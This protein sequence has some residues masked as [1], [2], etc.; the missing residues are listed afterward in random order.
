MIKRRTF[1]KHDFYDVH[2]TD[3]YEKRVKETYIYLSEAKNEFGYK[4]Y[5]DDFAD[6]WINRVKKFATDLEVPRNLGVVEPEHFSDTYSHV[7]VP[8][9]ETTIFLL[10]ED[11]QIY[12]ATSGWSRAPWRTILEERQSKIEQ[13]ISE[14]KTEKG[15]PKDNKIIKPMSERSA[16]ERAKWEKE[17]AKGEQP[18]K[19]QVKGDHDK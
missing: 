8:D 16:K 12:L 19:D 18:K 13:A 11:N 5:P 1:I 4:K 6:K 9:T 10:V 3:E 14:K 7:Q 15:Q 2:S 17:K